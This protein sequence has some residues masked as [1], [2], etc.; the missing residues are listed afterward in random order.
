MRIGLLFVLL[1]ISVVSYGQVSVTISTEKQNYA[2]EHFNIIGVT[3]DRT[4]TDR[5]GTIQSGAL[6]VS[7]GLAEGLN[8]YFN[9][10]HPEAA[11]QIPVTMHI[12]AFE[13]KEKSLGKKRQFDL[14]ME[15]AYYAGS[16]KLVSYKGSSFAQS[17]DDY[18]PYIEK[19][20]RENINSNL[21]QFDQWV[22]KNKAT[23]SAEPVVNVKVYF[24]NLAS[25]TGH[26]AYQKS[27]KLYITDFEGP[28]DETSPGAAA[29]LSGVG[30]NY[31]I[32]TLR[33]VTDVDVT[34][35]A[36][37][38]RSRSWMKDNGKNVTIL[39]HEQR[40]FDITAIKACE[41]KKE[42][43]AT[44]FLPDTYKEQLKALLD[45]AEQAGVDMQNQYDRETEHGTLIDKQEEWNKKIL[46]MLAEQS[47]F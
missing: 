44:T 22:G 2:P 6:N 24:S 13:I 29:T 27:R 30:M 45:K 12:T 7:G 11:G 47:C 23:I 40:H 38:D 46:D 8:E 1:C 26:I 9:A 17:F 16:S 10:I 33:N 36:Y 18:L 25:K 41:L 35:M 4:E 37:F 15:I 20:I 19:L 32:S 21:K 28:P 43:E 39:Q 14:N 3:D 31:K 5:I 34:I 42:I